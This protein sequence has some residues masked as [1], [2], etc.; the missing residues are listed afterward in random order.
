MKF[1]APDST[2][3]FNCTEDAGVIVVTFLRQQLTDEDNIERL[4]ESLFALLEK[5]PRSR[6]V[7]DL[8]HLDFVT[9]AVVGKFITL[10]RRLHREGGA[11]VICALQ[12]NV[13]ET[14]R[15]SHLLEYF[16]TA[17]TVE[18]AKAALTT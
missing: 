10:H 3:H 1:A 5:D 7:L 2:S 12:S 9:S 17:D 8:S 18:A 4:G 14:L 16:E 13:R 6:I 11:L 15:A